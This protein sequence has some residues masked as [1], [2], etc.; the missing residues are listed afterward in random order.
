MKG[1]E[2]N[3][4]KEKT[5]HFLNK[6]LYW[7]KTPH[8][9]KCSELI[10]RFKMGS[11]GYRGFSTLNANR[12]LKVLIVGVTQQLDRVKGRDVK[13]TRLAL[14]LRLEQKIDRD[15]SNRT[16]HPCR[17]SWQR[18]PSSPL[19]SASPFSH[20]SARLSVQISLLEETARL[21][22]PFSARSSSH[23]SYDET[24]D[25]THWSC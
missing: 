11:F 18:W 8:I 2:E 23:R 10:A 7:V 4:Q 12:L 3:R 14:I 5:L 21:E 15:Y 1:K 20:C 24:D 22:K 17:R 13:A 6:S 16:S 9:D 25:V 19:P